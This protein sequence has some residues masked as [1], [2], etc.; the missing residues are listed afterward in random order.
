MWC[1]ILFFGLKLTYKYTNFWGLKLTY[2]YTN[3]WD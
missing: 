1:K 2:K 3:F